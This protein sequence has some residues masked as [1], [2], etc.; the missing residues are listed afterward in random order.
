MKSV[1]HSVYITEVKRS[2]MV[3]VI[4]LDRHDEQVMFYLTTNN[5][6][7]GNQLINNI[8]IITYYEFVEQR[9]KG[10]HALKCIL[11]FTHACSL[12]AQMTYSKCEYQA[13]LH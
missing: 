13:N 2:S 8:P 1:H 11:K 12:T 5:K 7:T 6:E 9:G 4:P 3:L 10:V